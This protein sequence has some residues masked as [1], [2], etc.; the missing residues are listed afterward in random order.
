MCFGDMVRDSAR[1]YQ[2]DYRSD[3]E[4]DI[5]EAAGSLGEAVVLHED[6][7]DSREHQV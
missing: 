1:D 7:G 5:S 3:T 4:S 2:A 6:C